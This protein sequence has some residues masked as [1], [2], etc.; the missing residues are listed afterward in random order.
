MA[1]RG[2]N[3]RTQ[4]LIRTV[5]VIVLASSGIAAVMAWAP[6]PIDRFN[7]AF[8]PKR[9]SARH[10]VGTQRRLSC[11]ECGVVESIR[12]VTLPG[13]LP[14]PTETDQLPGRYPQAQPQNTPSYEITVRMTD[15]SSRAITDSNGKRWRSGSRVVIIGSTTP[16]N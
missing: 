12:E 14:A 9:E 10:R 16:V 7:D 3:A 13:P 5:A 15:G 6:V 4:A 1:V 8:S 2:G 11:D